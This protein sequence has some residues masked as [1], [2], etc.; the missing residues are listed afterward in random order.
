MSRAFKI[1]RKI[2][3]YQTERENKQNKGNIE[4]GETNIK[5]K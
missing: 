4:H 1:K 5:E 2:V 3:K